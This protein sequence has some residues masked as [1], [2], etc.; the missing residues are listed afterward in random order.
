MGFFGLGFLCLFY[1]F[2]FCFVF[3]FFF[4]IERQK[5]SASFYVPFLQ[6]RN[7]HWKFQPSSWWSDI[8]IIRLYCN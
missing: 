3:V 5:C 7:F 6:D 8:C 2:C 4:S 1:M